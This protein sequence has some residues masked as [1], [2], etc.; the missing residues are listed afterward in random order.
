M[1]YYVSLTAQSDLD[2]IWLS[3]AKESNRIEI[4]N[5]VVDTIEDSFALIG[6]YP[7]RFS[8]GRVIL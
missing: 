2:R 4:A 6:R 5:R 3:L 1:A 8:F 7:S